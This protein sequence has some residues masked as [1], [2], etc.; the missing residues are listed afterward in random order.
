MNRPVPQARRKPNLVSKLLAFQEK[1][2]VPYGG[3]AGRRDHVC[4][5]K[6]C[7]EFKRVLK[8]ALSANGHDGQHSEQK[9][10]PFHTSLFGLWAIRMRG[11]RYAQSGNC[12]GSRALVLVTQ[13][14]SAGP[15]CALCAISGKELLSIMKERPVK[16]SIKSRKRQLK[17][18]LGSCSGRLSLKAVVSRV[19]KPLTV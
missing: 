15:L 3:A 11:G 6:G 17:L 18:I 13:K 9:D 14:L 7:S 1:F 8:H 5:A 2:A 12:A 4:S 19:K 10:H 16:A